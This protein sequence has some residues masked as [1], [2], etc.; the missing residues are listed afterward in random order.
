MTGSIGVI[1]LAAALEAYFL[2]PASWIERALFLAAALLLIDPQALTYV[3]GLAVL[4]VA[5][6]SQKLRPVGQPRPAE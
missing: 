3:I 4:G 6:L 5:L 1:A 2:R